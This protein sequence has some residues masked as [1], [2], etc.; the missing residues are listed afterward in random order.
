[1][2]LLQLPLRLLQAINTPSAEKFRIWANSTL[3]KWQTFAQR[4]I[5]LPSVHLSSH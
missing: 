5:Y 2:K 4:E 1:M 3:E